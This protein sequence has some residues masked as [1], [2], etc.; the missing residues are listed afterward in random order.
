MYFL[1]SSHVN[2]AVSALDP[3]DAGQAIRETLNQQ[4]QS[5]S[6]AERKWRSDMMRVE[7]DI[8]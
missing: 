5:D 3:A 2:S 8:V 4:R 7:A 6:C 1:V